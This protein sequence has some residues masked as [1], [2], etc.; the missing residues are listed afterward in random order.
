[1][2]PCGEGFYNSKLAA[3]ESPPASSGT[4]PQEYKCGRSSELRD[5][6][7]DVIAILVTRNVDAS[8]LSQV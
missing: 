3:R 2:E 6:W 5:E 4:S 7:E 1:V 8:T